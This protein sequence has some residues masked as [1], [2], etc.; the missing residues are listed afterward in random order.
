MTEKVANKRTLYSTWINSGLLVFIAGLILS[1]FTDI[2]EI[3]SRTP[4]NVQYKVRMQDHVDNVTFS[5]ME[6]YELVEHAKDSTV[7]I[8]KEERLLIQNQ[9]SLLKIV[10]NEQWSQG[11]RQKK[12]AKDTKL[13]LRE[14]KK[15][16]NQ[17]P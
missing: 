4:D 6:S 10:I 2:K 8:S 11:Q 16:K 7:H 12:Q 13:I 17:L 9:D 15:I 5:E 3:E 14:I 1:N